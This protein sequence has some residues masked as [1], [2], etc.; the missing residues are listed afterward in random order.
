MGVRVNRYA[1]PPG[2]RHAAEPVPVVVR[3]RLDGCP[4][5]ARWLCP[6]CLEETHGPL[7]RGPR[8]T[9]AG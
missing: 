4:E 3:D 2:C 8:V 5:V 9:A 7:P 6:L 1:P